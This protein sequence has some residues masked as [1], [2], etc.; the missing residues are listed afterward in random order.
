MDD[1]FVTAIP[2]RAR[3]L[4]GLLA[5]IVGGFVLAVI[6]AASPSSAE[7]PPPVSV[8]DHVAGVLDSVTDPVAAVTSTVVDEVVAVVEPIEHSL[9]PAGVA[10]VET[11]TDEVAG[12]SVG[13]VAA[14]VVTVA[15][16]VI[17]TVVDASQTPLLTG[18]LGA[19]PVKTVTTPVVGA[20]DDVVA[21]L[22]NP[23]GVATPVILPSILEAS[24]PPDGVADRAAILTQQA[25]SAAQEL[26]PSADAATVASPAPGDAFSEPRG[27]ASIVSTGGSTAVS[28]TGGGAAPVAVAVDRFVPLPST[29]R[30]AAD[31][32]HRLPNSPVPDSDSSPD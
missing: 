20:I 9:P 15:D 17:D 21:S 2:H 7:E 13:A 31:A 27:A 25:M 8:V 16:S 19:S 14:P 10:V 29:G 18:L 11:L 5:A 23:A 28:G 4:I 30:G 22:R 3:L 32:D 26:T 12:I 1:T 24:E 6:A